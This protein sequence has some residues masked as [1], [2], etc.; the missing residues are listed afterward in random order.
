MA[1]DARVEYEKLFRIFGGWACEG[2]TSRALEMAGDDAITPAQFRC[3]D[4][5]ARRDSCSVGHLAAGLAIS[6]P[7][8][9]KLI[10]RVQDKGLVARRAS[11]RNHRVVHVKLSQLGVSL[12][13]KLIR[14]RDSLLC[15]PMDALSARQLQQMARALDNILM[16][17]LDCPE[18][19]ERVCLR[20]DGDHSPECVVNRARVTLA[21]ADIFQFE[22]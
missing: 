5:L 6:D 11:R 10:D 7:A 12:A 14:R 3:L 16:S 20:C 1:L 4:F 17:A 19:I 8:A 2:V 18:I 9:T 22:V 15:S 21:G 13:A